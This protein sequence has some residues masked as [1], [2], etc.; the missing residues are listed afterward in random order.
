MAKRLYYNTG[1]ITHLTDE[2]IKIIEDIEKFNT[3]S[4]IDS[5]AGTG[6]TTTICSMV[7]YLVDYYDIEPSELMLITYTKNA[8]ISMKY[9]LKSYMSKDIEYLGTIHSIAYQQILNGEINNRNI[10]ENN[11]YSPCEILSI[12]H[13]YIDQLYKNTSYENK[14]SKLKYLLVD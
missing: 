7:G 1:K 11:Y 2:Q 14:L 9:K 4:I 10:N 8:H 13:R 5:T 6:K 12:F 3:W